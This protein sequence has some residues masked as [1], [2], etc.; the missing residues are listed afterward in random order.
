MYALVPWPGIEPKPSALGM[1][2]FNGWTTKEVPLKIFFFLNSGH[3]V[4]KDSRDWSTWY[5]C[6]G[7][8]LCLSVRP[9]V[10]EWGQASQ[11]WRWLWMSLLLESPST[12]QTS[13]RFSGGILWL[14]PGGCC[15]C[16][17]T[18]LCPTLC[19][20][21]NSSTPI[22]SF[23]ISLSLLQ[24]MSI[25]SVMLSNHLILCR[26]LL[27]LSSILRS[28]SQLFSNEL[29]L[30]IRWP[31]YW[32]FNFSISPSNEIFRVD[33]SLGLTGWISLLSK[34][35]SQV[36]SGIPVWKHQFFGAQ[37]SLWSNSHIRC[38]PLEIGPHGSLSALCPM[39]S[40][41]C[42]SPALDCWFLL[43]CAWGFWFKRKMV[44]GDGWAFLPVCIWGGSL[45]LL[46]CLQSFSWET[47]W[48]SH[49]IL[50]M[51]IISSCVWSAQLF[52]MSRWPPLSF[53]LKFF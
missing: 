17:V 11:R 6:P 18:K 39:G 8:G 25:E 29:A 32:S 48:S 41:S 14:L 16:S 43:P 31:E 34:G 12:L 19:D 5:L 20:P 24:L 36:F 22:N 38:R 27:L 33:F 13:D 28:T 51:S 37:P 46:H 42:P 47:W 26:P 50:W 7:M 44:Q 45:W 23:T 40:L 35:L 53:Q 21:M 30:H 10:G 4:L 1:W 52:N 2:I 9:L 49:R 15:Q 3:C